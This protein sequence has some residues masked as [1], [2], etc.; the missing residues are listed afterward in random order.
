[1][2]TNCVVVVLSA[3]AVLA[4]CN[5]TGEPCPELEAVLQASEQLP[6]PVASW[7]EVIGDLVATAPADSVTEFTIFLD[8]H[9][10]T[11][12]RAWAEATGAEIVYEFRSFSGFGVHAPVSALPGLLP[13]ESITGIS[14]STEA[15]MT[16]GNL[17]S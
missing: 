5:P 2:R 6:P 17:C 3:G 8:R 4:G 16:Y 7:R 11:E 12:L 10:N 14:W 1:M 15:N 9:G 13:Q